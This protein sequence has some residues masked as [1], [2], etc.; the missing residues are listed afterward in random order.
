MHP[1]SA[2]AGRSGGSQAAAWLSVALYETRDVEREGSVGLTCRQSVVLGPAADD[3]N[4]ALAGRAVKCF[5]KPL[6]LSGVRSGKVIAQDGGKT[7]GFGQTKP[8]TEPEPDW[9]PQPVL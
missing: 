6:H 3:E 7:Q 5:A 9:R 4:L 2:G 1:D 8:K